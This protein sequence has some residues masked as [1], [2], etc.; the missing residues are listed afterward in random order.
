MP[1]FGKTSTAGAFLSLGQNNKRVNKRTLSEA[2]SLSKLWVYVNGLGEGSGNEVCV[3]LA[4]SDT[5][6]APDVLLATSAEITVLDGQAA[7]WVSGVVS[8]GPLT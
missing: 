4:Y 1:T 7:G 8:P 2:G 5:A 6:G 3:L